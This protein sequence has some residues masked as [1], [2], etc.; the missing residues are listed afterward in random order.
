MKSTFTYGEKLLSI[1]LVVCIMVALIALVMEVSQRRR[2]EIAE[3]RY[4]RNEDWIKKNFQFRIGGTQEHPSY[5]LDQGKTWYNWTPG[6]GITPAD[7]ELV[8]K[9]DGF[10]ALTAYVEAN[11]PIQINDPEG[12]KVLEGAGFTVE[13]KKAETP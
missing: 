7:P 5:S 9:L 2:A 6:G 13:R 3:S 10:A 1:L 4:Q 8:R 11:G 12:L